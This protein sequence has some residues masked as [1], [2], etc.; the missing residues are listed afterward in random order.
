MLKLTDLLAVV[1]TEQTDAVHRAEEANR[2]RT[3]L[4]PLEEVRNQE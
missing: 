1:E 2:D 3:F 4:E